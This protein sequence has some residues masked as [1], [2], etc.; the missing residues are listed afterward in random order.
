MGLLI[1]NS[2]V[3]L[4]IPITMIALGLYFKRSAP[5][6]IN[7]FFGYRTKRSMKN[8]ETWAFAH[9]YCGRLLVRVG[10]GMTIAT[11]VIVIFVHSFS[12]FGAVLMLVQIPGMIATT[13]I[14]ERALDRTFDEYG[15]RR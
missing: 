14:T 12:A 9:A 6:N 13:L 11:A 4:I 1:Y 10:I 2:I 5:K 7:Y 3:A 8:R 15:N